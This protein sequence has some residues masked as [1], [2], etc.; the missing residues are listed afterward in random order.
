MMNTSQKINVLVEGT[1][2]NVSIV[3]NEIS[4]LQLQYSLVLKSSK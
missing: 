2:G 3:N 4:Q 1:K